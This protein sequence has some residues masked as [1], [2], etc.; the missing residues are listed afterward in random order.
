MVQCKLIT[1]YLTFIAILTCVNNI[2]LLTPT[3]G[4]YILRQKSSDKNQ[5]KTNRFDM[6]LKRYASP[7]QTS[8]IWKGSILYMSKTGLKSSANTMF[9]TSHFDT[10]NTKQKGR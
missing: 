2:S 8:M 9:L 10:H 1:I 3:L 4:G 5:R 6:G 7:D